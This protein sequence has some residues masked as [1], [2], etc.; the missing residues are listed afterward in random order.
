MWQWQD[1]QV[2][3][4]KVVVIRAM[5]VTVV[6]LVV[7]TIVVVTV[8]VVVFVVATIVL[9]LVVGSGDQGG[10]R[11]NSE[12]NRGGDTAKPCWDFQPDAFKLVTYAN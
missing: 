2:V 12:C 1:I 3:A 7:V 5:M 4:G 11:W 9:V 10:G 6:V 8:V